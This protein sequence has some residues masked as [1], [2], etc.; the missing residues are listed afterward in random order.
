MNFKSIRTKIIL[1]VVALFL[2]GIGLMIFMT[3][4]KTKKEVTVEIYE[5]SENIIREVSYSIE[6][7]L[8]QYGKGAELLSTEK[9]ISTF[10]GTEES[11]VTDQEVI[12]ELQGFIGIYEDASS[13]YFAMPSKKTLIYPVIDLEGFDPTSRS[14]YELAKSTPDKVQWSEP[15]V[16][17]S[18]GEFVI[19][20]SK[21]VQSN[22]E[23]VGVVGLDIQLSA[24]TEKISASNIGYKGFLVLY[25]QKGTAISHPTNSGENLMDMPYVKS[26]YDKEQG[27][28]RFTDKNGTTDVTVF[29]TLPEFGWKLGA[30]YHEKDLNKLPR[31]LRNSMFVIALIV[32][33][34]I[35]AGIYVMVNRM[36]KP[37][38]TLKALM[39]EAS[40]GDLTVQSSIKSRDEIG[41][42]GD[43]FNKMI[44]NMR[45]IINVVTVSADNVRMSS[46]SLSAVSEE[47]SASS[48]EVA[49]AVGEIAE[50]AS[51]SAEDSEVV[52]E[53]TDELGQ[54]IN[55]INERA[56][57]MTA[58][59]ENTSVMNANGQKQMGELKD[60]FVSS[61]VNLQ[62]MSEVISTLG[63]RV[64]AI[65][66]VMETIT[67]IS[68][69]TN[70]LALNASIEAARAGEH[71]KGFAVVADEVRKLAEQSARA[72]EDVKVTVLEL[73]QESHVVTTQMD[74]T[75]ETFRN[76]G[77]VVE[78]TETTFQKLSEM[79]KDMQKSID[80]ISHEIKNVSQHKDDVSITI[81]TMA[82]TSQ[83]TAAAC[84]EVSASTEEQ[85]RAIQ[86]VTDAAETL[87][88]LSEEL[89]N[90]ISRFRV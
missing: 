64:K 45:S 55:G 47:T 46:E 79:M 7:F 3:N 1:T 67:D 27:T 90:A 4:D 20:A 82:A 73:Q 84:E 81:Q 48:S 30:V 76:Q 28:N 25:D 24:L 59:A 19:T 8:G 65:G 13:A 50:G 42:L 54:Q 2:I 80:S 68:A 36:I 83:E 23:F 37:I 71:G 87:T 40:E 66:G 56:S 38:G 53:R 21:A 34:I 39:D 63:E 12:T 52:T 88:E 22:G 57:E 16:D 6:N 31:L 74:E 41:Q 17:E 60:T 61:G 5:N 75:I 35:S 70:L 85:L 49:H 43:N 33:V 15:Y 32:L 89:T 9:T 77:I 62:T 58:I 69:Q 51:K 29:K 86:S 10:T 14:W 11:E 78:E 44:S 26:L 72:T 18:T